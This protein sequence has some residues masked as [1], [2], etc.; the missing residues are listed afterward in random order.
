M[1]EYRDLY[2][3]PRAGSIR[4][5]PP[6]GLLQAPRVARA[7]AGYAASRRLRNV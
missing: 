7:V 5:Q 4:I 6:G 1:R 3:P 2:W